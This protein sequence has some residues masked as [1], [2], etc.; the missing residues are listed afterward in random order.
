MH[1]IRVTLATHGHTLYTCVYTPIYPM[2]LHGLSG[3]RTY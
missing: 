1:S 2:N 3:N